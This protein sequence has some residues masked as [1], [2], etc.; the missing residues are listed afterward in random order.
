MIS[1]DKKL[2]IPVGRASCELI[3]NC[4]IKALLQLFQYS[5]QKEE[6]EMHFVTST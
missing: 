4:V 2:Q 5:Q 6:M 3:E 1:I